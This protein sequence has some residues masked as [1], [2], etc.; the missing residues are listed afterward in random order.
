MADDYF[1]VKLA[2]N[3]ETGNTVPGAV[4]QVY[5]ADDTSFTSPLAITDLTGVPL[6]ALIASP[7][8]IYPAFRVVSGLQRVVA[9]SGPLI[10]PITSA[11]GSRGPKG[12]PGDAGSGVDP[13]G[14]APG[15]VLTSTGPSSEPQWRDAPASAGIQGAPSAWP[16]AF[17]PDTHT[18][19]IGAIT[20]VTDVGRQL[21]KATT[22][23][24]AR[25]AI[26]AGTG[27]GTSNLTLGTTSS[28]AARGDHS[29]TAAAIPFTPT[30][31][32]TAQNL[33]DAVVQAAATG[34]G[35]GGTAQVQVL[36]FASGAYPAF[37]ATKPTGVNMFV[38]IGP[39]TPTSGNVSGGIPTYVGN[40][41][42]QI[43]AEFRVN[44]S[45]T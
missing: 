23:Q 34:S 26:G 6:G 31:P 45:L 43:P 25:A 30:G 11:E 28:T 29:H 39:V 9:K 14:S 33:Q 2:L 17:P 4:A 42:T 5:A 40:S 38:L 15:Q 24:E 44:A 22:A 32:I 3:P 1:D 10:T 12:D 19:G 16:S 21:A 20:D 18:H 8:G 7:T 35:G 27:N 41:P 36:R 37:P 13:S